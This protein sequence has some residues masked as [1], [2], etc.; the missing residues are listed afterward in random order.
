[1]RNF[2]FYMNYFLDMDVGSKSCASNNMDCQAI[3]EEDQNYIQ[4]NNESTRNMVIPVTSGPNV[5]PYIKP[6]LRVVR[7]PDWKWGDQ[8]LNYFNS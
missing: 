4:F 6:G 2:L 1:M 7:G 3:F 5:V 8:V